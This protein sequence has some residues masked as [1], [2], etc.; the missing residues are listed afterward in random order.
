MHTANK[1]H[2]DQNKAALEVKQA[3]YGETR[4]AN[5]KKKL[6]KNKNK[7]IQ[8]EA[9]TPA[10]A[11]QQSSKKTDNRAKINTARRYANRALSTET[12]LDL[13]RRET[14]NFF[15]MAE[16]VGKWV[17]IQFENKQPVTVT[18]VLSELGFHWNNTRQ[19]WQHPCGTITDERATYDPRKRYGSYFAAQQA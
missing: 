15:Q 11:V 18:S 7:K 19:A 10:N 13:L 9:A 3:T 2:F 12:L 14:P 1:T 17:W 6:M 5:I 4:T 16:V 8:I